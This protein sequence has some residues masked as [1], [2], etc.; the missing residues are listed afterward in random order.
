MNTME[1]LKSRLNLR[2]GPTQWAG[3]CPCH[4]D[5]HASLNIKRADDGTILL[6]CQAGCETK[7]ICEAL[8]IG[9]KDLF[10]NKVE[11]AQRRLVEEYDYTD[12]TG[13][14]LFQAVRFEPKDFRQRRPDNNGGYTWGLGNTRR[15]V[16]RLPELLKTNLGE[17]IFICEGEKDVENLRAL[18]LKSTCNPMG[19]G[20]WN[21]EYNQWFKNRHVTVIVDNDEPG[22]NH[23]KDIYASLK[24]IVAEIKFIYFSDKPEHYDVSQWLNNGG[25]KDKLFGLVESAPTKPVDKDFS[26]KT[27]IAKTRE[28]TELIKQ[29]KIGRLYLPWPTVSGVFGGEGVPM[30]TIGLLVSLTGVGKSW[31]GY[32]MALHATDPEAEREPIPTFILNTEMNQNLYIGR[33]VALLDKN[34]MV[35][36]PGNSA[37][38]D[39]FTRSLSNVVE[40]LESRRLEITDTGDYDIQSVVKLIEDKV[41]DG[42]KFIIIDHLGEIDCLGQKEYEAFPKFVKRLRDI[43]RR[44]H[45]LILII[46]HLRKDQNGNV[47][48]AYCKRI[49]VPVDFAFGFKAFEPEAFDISTSCG[50]MTRT[51]NRSLR[52]LKN[53]IGISDIDIAFNFDSETLSMEDFGKLKKKK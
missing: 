32:H 28:Y 43:T 21:R 39:E 1:I 13:K 19:A 44:N 15:V 6:K 18:G 11:S 53:R 52:I 24:N 30:G 2:G 38:A 41:N 51:I 8:G 37:F 17:T 27:A 48:L 33:L 3:R 50:T 14:L 36:M 47:D 35:S 4:D 45:V 42:Y 12:E 10:P 49:Q 46:S 34:P 20:K 26:L 7:A 5:K 25:T 16:Y 9:L 22:R 40:C 31:L 29:G 23:A